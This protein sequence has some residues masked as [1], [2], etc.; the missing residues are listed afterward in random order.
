VLLPKNI[1]GSIPPLFISDCD[2]D[3]GTLP[4]YG[5][6][7]PLTRSG[8]RGNRGIAGVAGGLSGGGSIVVFMTLIAISNRFVSFAKSLM[9]PSR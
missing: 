8:L 4:S 7:V 9:V 1:D 3:N 5:G 6:R 2:G